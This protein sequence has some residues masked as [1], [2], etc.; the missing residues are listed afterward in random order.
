MTSKLS[1]VQLQ[2]S[3]AFI[4]KN[5]RLLERK[6][7][8]YFFENGSQQACLKALSAYQNEDGG[9][10]NGIEPDLMCPD[11]SGIGAE[12]ALSFLDLLEASNTEIAHK[13][14]DWIITHQNAEGYIPHPPESMLNYPYQPWWKNPDKER[15]LS[16]AAILKKWGFEQP[17]FFGKVKACYASLPFPAQ[18]EFYNYPFFLYL[19]YCSSSDQD[20]EQLSAL[21]SQ[22]P[23]FLAKFSNYFP[24]FSKYWSFARDY[25]GREVFAKEAE[26]FLNAL[27]DD[28]GIVTPYPDFPWWDPIFLLDGLIQLKRM[29]E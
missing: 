18:L 10:G 17:E 16:L 25:V 7:F 14:I 23:A 29:N 20:R 24:L 4:Y 26:I 5:G 3:K 27:K 9:F 21:A 1:S 8:E 22:L 15:I 12:T 2:K 6:L 13:L 28:G 11:S 19:K